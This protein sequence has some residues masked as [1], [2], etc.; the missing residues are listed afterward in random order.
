VSLNRNLGLAALVLGAAAPFA[1]SPYAAASTDHV[2]SLAREITRGEDHISALQLAAWIKA[3][4]PGLRVIDVRSPDEFAAYSLPGAENIPLDRLSRARFAQGDT[5]VLYSEEG[6][7]AGQAWMLLRMTG[8]AHAYFIAG[9][10]ADW[11]DEVMSPNLPEGAS[12]QVVRAFEPVAQLSAYFG[13]TPRRGPAGSTPTQ[14]NSSAPTARIGAA[15][16][17][18]ALR[19]RGC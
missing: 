19:R 16:D 17:L 12:P 7:H 3:R 11:R 2:D 1:G 4:K 14:M 5:V 13:G 15:A 8:V 6:A 18:A 9:G 10:L